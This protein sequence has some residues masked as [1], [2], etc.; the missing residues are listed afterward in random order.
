MKDSI[1]H[2][3]K[4]DLTVCL[5]ATATLIMGGMSRLEMEGNTDE[6]DLML[7]ASDQVVFADIKCGEETI[8]QVTIGEIVGQLKAQD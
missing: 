8:D 3:K 6:F 5:R 7:I 2:F 4:T 1:I